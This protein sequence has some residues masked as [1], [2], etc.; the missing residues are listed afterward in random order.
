ML[1]TF[2]TGRGQIAALTLLAAGV[3][4]I[5][6]GGAQAVPRPTTCPSSGNSKAPFYGVAAAQI[7]QGKPVHVAGNYRLK[8]R[9]RKLTLSEMGESADLLR[10]K[11]SSSPSPGKAAGCPNFGGEFNA[12]VSVKQVQIID[13]KKQK[14]TVRVGRPHAKVSAAR[15]STP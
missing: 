3:T 6:S 12:A 1:A 4:A 2:S 10:L 15:T 5:S 9:N 14:I 11:L 8:E 13:W 7:G